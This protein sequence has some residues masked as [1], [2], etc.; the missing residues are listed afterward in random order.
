ME[1]IKEQFQR[2]WEEV[3]A[4]VERLEKLWLT[5]RTHPDLQEIDAGHSFVKTL[6]VIIAEEK[7]QM[8][9]LAAEIAKL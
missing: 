9:R 4:R 6:S 7:F 5:V 2:M 1:P 8:N 3:F